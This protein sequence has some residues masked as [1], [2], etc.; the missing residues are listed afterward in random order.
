MNHTQDHYEKKT[1]RLTMSRRSFIVTTATATGGLII[2]LQ[3][4]AC[5]QG[6]TK[7]ISTVEGEVF[8]W[9]VIAPDNTVT[10]RIAQMEIGQGTMTAMAQLLAEELEVD[11]SK[12][13]VEFINLATHLNRN[14]IYGRTSTALSAGVYLSE[15]PLRIAGAQIRTMFVK[16]AAKR[17][18]VS[19]SELK[20]EK[21]MVIHTATGRKLT[22]GELAVDAAKI[23]VPDPES[24][25]IKNPK[26]WTSIGRAIK[27]LDIPPMVDGTTV[28]GMDV[29]VPGMKF[30]AIAMC[31]V[32][33]GRLKSYDREVARS[34]KGALKVVEL[35]DALAVVADDWWQAKSILDQIPKAWDYGSLAS[36][37]SIEMLDNYKTGF[38]CPADE[39][40][41]D[42]GNTDAVMKDSTRILESDYFVPYL[43]HAQIE[44]MNCTALVTDDGFEVWTG[45][46]Q[47]E[48][49]F[50]KAAMALESEK[51]VISRAAS[52][53]GRLVEKVFD[54]PTAG[55]NALNVL[56]AGGS[57]G[58]RH[59]FDHIVQAVRI[60]HSMKGTPVKLIWSRE[61]TMR[62][63]YFRPAIF[64]KLRAALDQRGNIAAWSQ[65]MVAQSNCKKLYKVGLNSLLYAIPNMRVDFV[66]RG[67]R[68]PIGPLRGI[69]FPAHCFFTQTFVD[70]LAE[71]AGNDTYQF[72]KELLDP[73]KV[74]LSV[75]LPAPYSQN[76]QPR[77]RAARLR[78]VLDKAALM[79]DWNSPMGKNRGRGIAVHEQARSFFAYVVEV[80]LDN[81]GWFSIDRVVAA[82]DPGYLVNPLN[83]EAQ[84]EGSVAFAL[85]C[86]LYGEITLKNGRVA[87]SNYHD[88]PILLMNEMP[89]VE[90]HW[91]LSAKEWGG[92]G[93]AAVSSVIPALTNAIYNA[94]GP[95]IRS[96]PIKNHKILKRG[97]E[98]QAHG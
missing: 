61:D 8:N 39:I 68:L 29:K 30:A 92:L 52:K 65:R 66:G 20:A 18:G 27:R 28:F 82:V 87:E 15:N 69:G 89:K 48:K 57:F 10:M 3:F 70:E 1:A 85:T 40:F 83:A 59:K 17:L 81:K 14:K 42:D 86:G 71:M 46:Q 19:A 49:A 72:Q 76:N 97:Q 64:S 44:P 35:D 32:F 43:A 93:D 50:E 96:L 23:E 4:P 78:A 24:V 11:W 34:F 54:M 9:V 31:P 60:A 26:D 41:R 12:V 22:Y 84:I 91:V 33:K 63:V 36:V 75:P 90:V 45:T 25:T 77:V 13:K 2:G 47:P 58:S 37:D 95:R 94:G 16:A 79:A 56:Q 73:D 6:P 55:S 62:H 80:T 21:S 38:Q 98:G 88:Y 74:P 7:S 53:V 5:T 67:P 51:N